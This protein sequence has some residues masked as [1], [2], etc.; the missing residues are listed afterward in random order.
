MVEGY[1]K[2][3]ALVQI[4]EV[5]KVFSLQTWGPVQNIPHP[6]PPL[7]PPPPPLLLGSIQN[8]TIVTTAT[9]TSARH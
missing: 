1:Q 5:N 8:K 4:R 3:E 7:S 6:P 2:M 9:N